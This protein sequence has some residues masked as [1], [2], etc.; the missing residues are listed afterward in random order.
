MVYHNEFAVSITKMI[1]IF[2]PFLIGIGI[3]IG[4]IIHHRINWYYYNSPH[5]FDCIYLSVSLLCHIGSFTLSLS[6]YVIPIVFVFFFFLL[7]RPYLS[8]RLFIVSFRIFSFLFPCG[9]NL[10][11]VL[12]LSSLFGPINLSISSLCRTRSFPHSLLCRY[13]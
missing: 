11:R 10:F 9:C 8:I 12:L 13:S 3:I 2:L 1:Q 5:P 4:I 6:L 7:L